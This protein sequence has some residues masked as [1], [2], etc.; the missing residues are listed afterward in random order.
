MS[1]VVNRVTGE[2]KK[3]VNT[4][5]YPTADWIIN[6]DLSSLTSVPNKYWKVSGDDVLEMTQAEK[7]VV[8]TPYHWFY[9]CDTED[10]FFCEIVG[11]EPTQCKNSAG[12]TISEVFNED[13][14]DSF[15]EGSDIFCLY[16]E[17]TEGLVLAK[18][19]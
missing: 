13:P 7:D 12:H 2:L 1:D 6:P 4:P 8:H 17:A 9:H 14:Q 19:L 11:S 15:Q 5:D 18:E 16:A 10:K 3:S